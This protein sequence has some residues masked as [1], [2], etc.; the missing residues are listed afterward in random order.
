[1]KGQM[2]IELKDVKTG[3]VERHVDHNMV[4]NAI[5]NFF[6]TGGL[7]N[8]ITAD[9]NNLVKDLLGGIML[10]DGNIE[11]L[12]TN[13]F[14]PTSVNMV[15][16][17]AVDTLSSDSVLEMGSWNEE[18]SGWQQDGSYVQVYDFTTSQANAT[19]ACACL[20]SN[21]GGYIGLGNSI[22]NEVKSNKKYIYNYNQSDGNYG[23][24]NGY[25]ILRGEYTNSWIDVIKTTQLSYSQDDSIFKTGKI[26]ISRYLIPLRKI[27]LNGTLTSFIKVADYELTVPQSFIN[28]VTAN[29]ER[30]LTYDVDSEGNIYFYGRY[31][32]WNASNPWHIL[33]I[34]A[35]NTITDLALLNTLGV[36]IAKNNQYAYFSFEAGYALIANANSTYVYRISLSDSSSIEMGNIGAN[37]NATALI[38]KNNGW[39]LL[40][41]GKLINVIKGKVLNY[42]GTRSQ[43]VNY[44]KFLDV[45]YMSLAI[46][47]YSVSVLRNALYIATIN[48]LE[49]PVTKT[50]EKT[51]KVT[52]R[53]TFNE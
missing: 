49:S 24:S 31:G 39:I 45:D 34:G 23:F 47:T 16:C 10:F 28:A 43:N 17:G 7:M 37:W 13:T 44:N 36:D 51:M 30:N 53:L 15:G 29:N 21:V 6:K 46:S 4:T 22:S 3:E 50:A 14:P 32:T 18:E 40:A 35:D 48:N 5:S 25:T 12:A 11:E 38:Y 52:Y 33:K 42:N 8:R 9:K 41:E 2:I 19:I 20:T 27:P 26:V 1:M